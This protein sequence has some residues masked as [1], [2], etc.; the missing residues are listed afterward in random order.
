[1]KRF[2]ITETRT[3]DGKEEVAS[4]EVLGTKSQIIKTIKRSNPFP[5]MFIYNLEKNHRAE[6]VE[7]K[8]TLRLEIM[9]LG[10]A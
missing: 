10:Q 1:M 7:G 9:E 4:R 2:K 8:N 3:I 5:T 6:Y